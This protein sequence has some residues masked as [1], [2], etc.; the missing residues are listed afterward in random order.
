MKSKLILWL[1]VCL[2]YNALYR[3][4][5]AIKQ[6][7]DCQGPKYFEYDHPQYDLP[8]LEE[9][10]SEE[11]Q[12]YLFVQAATKIIMPNHTDPDYTD[13]CYNITREMCDFCCLIDFEFCSRDIGICEPISDRNLGL[14]MDCVIVFTGILCGFPIVI[15]CCSCFI[16]YRFGSFYYTRTNGVSCYEVLIRMSCFLFC[17]VSF[18]ETYK[19]SDDDLLEAEN[20]KKGWWY[21]LFCCFLC[22]CFFRS[23][24]PDVAATEGAEE[25][26]EGEEDY[27]AVKDKEGEEGEGE[28]GAE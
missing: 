17:C 22:P 11:T 9:V 28:E 20:N 6:Y 13:V 8:E 19:K 5:T 12:N 4:H 16:S 3:I 21:Y 27:E 25:G 10:A 26:A 1:G 18:S 14:I 7:D 23:K 2:V 24:Q 15:K